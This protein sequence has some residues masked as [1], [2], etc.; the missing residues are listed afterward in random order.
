MKWIVRKVDFYI[1]RYD[2]RLSNVDVTEYVMFRRLELGCLS[3]ATYW[4]ASASL[5]ETG[6]RQLRVLSV[7]DISFTL[8]TEIW[9][10]SLEFFMLWTYEVGSTFELVKN[11]VP[12]GNRQHGNY[13]DLRVISIHQR[14]VRPGSHP[15]RTQSSRTYRLLSLTVRRLLIGWL[16]DWRCEKRDRT[17]ARSLQRHTALATPTRSD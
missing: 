5:Q 13:F 8:G 4:P 15:E 6:L 12:V 3:S 10:I 17:S 1:A 2:L 14:E 16:A 9:A 7:R 11:S